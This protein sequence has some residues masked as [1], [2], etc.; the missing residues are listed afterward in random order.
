MG[1]EES[2]PEVPVKS[3]VPV[4]TV[5]FFIGTLCHP[6][7]V[8]SIDRIKT[9]PSQAEMWYVFNIWLGITSHPEIQTI[10]AKQLT[11]EIVWDTF[12]VPFVKYLIIQGLQWESK[13]F[14]EKMKQQFYLFGR[15]LLTRNIQDYSVRSPFWEHT[16]NYLHHNN[17]A[18]AP[19]CEPN[20]LDMENPILIAE[21]VQDLHTSV[22]V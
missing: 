16:N 13:F 11:N 2:K 18:T 15:E 6:I 17:I 1:Q 21:S 19:V 12:A 9:N 14:T 4:K 22:V 10:T 3:E 20:L 5:D 7:Q 8:D